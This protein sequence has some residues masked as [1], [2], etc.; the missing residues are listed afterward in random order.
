MSLADLLRKRASMELH[1]RWAA[2]YPSLE[3][4]ALHG[5]TDPDGDGSV[6]MDTGHRLFLAASDGHPDWHLH[7]THASDGDMATRKVVAD[8]GPGDEG[9]GD[10]VVK[11]LGHPD[12]MQGMRRLM[13]PPQPGEWWQHSVKV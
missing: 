8:L 12:V 10:R 2:A 3:K 6:P 1:P 11:A 7:V 9:V 13:T 4:H 5:F